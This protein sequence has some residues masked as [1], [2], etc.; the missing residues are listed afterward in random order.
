MLLGV[1]A[2]Q[3][4]GSLIQGRFFFFC[5]V[6]LSPVCNFSAVTD[7][8]VVVGSDSCREAED[9]DFLFS[10]FQYVWHFNVLKPLFNL[11]HLAHS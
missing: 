5:F 2:E 11:L 1:A 4:K 8:V 7:Q 6:F 9:P 3:E 10:I